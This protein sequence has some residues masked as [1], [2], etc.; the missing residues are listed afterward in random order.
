M[1]PPLCH[2]QP[3][4]YEFWVFFQKNREIFTTL[5]HFRDYMFV[6]LGFREYLIVYNISL[7]KLSE[8]LFRFN[9]HAVH[10][11]VIFR[12]LLCIFPGS[13]VCSAHCICISVEQAIPLPPTWSRFIRSGVRFMSSSLFPARSGF[14]FAGAS[15]AFCG[16]FPQTCGRILGWPATTPE[17]PLHE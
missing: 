12:G 10:M 6:Y 8:Y 7:V 13:S 5:P 11:F 14:L 9:Q 1:P 16:V 17:K 3:L 4:F 15:R 2:L